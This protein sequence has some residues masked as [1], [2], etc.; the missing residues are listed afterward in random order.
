ML[1]ASFYLFTNK[2]STRREGLPQRSPRQWAQRGHSNLGVSPAGAETVSCFQTLFYLFLQT[3]KH[4]TGFEPAT[5]ALARRYSTTEPLVHFFLYPVFCVPSKP[6][7]ELP[8]PSKQPFWISPRPI[9]DS[10]L[11]TLLHFHLCPIYLVVFKGSYFFRMGY[12]IL[13]GASRLDAFSVYPVRTWLPG[14]E[15]SGSTGAPAVRPS[16]SSR[17]KDSSSQ[18]SY[19]HA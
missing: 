7:T 10:Q 6:H 13:R 8:K 9:S 15:P 19:A 17:T 3:K 4:E 14:R 16:R 12:L 11:R 2:K 1:S 5:L 18:I